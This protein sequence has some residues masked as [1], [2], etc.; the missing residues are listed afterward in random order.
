MIAHGKVI[1]LGEHAVVF[2][3][4]ALAGALAMGVTAVASAASADRLEIPSWDPAA[5]WMEDPA[6]PLRRALAAIKAALDVHAPLAIVAQA[7]LPPG[8][9]L[10]SSAA[11]AVAL[12]RAIAAAAGRDLGDDEVERA[13]S[14]AERVFH[15]NPSGID[16]A[17]ATRGGI[18]LFRRGAGLER[19]AVP[20]LR[21]AIG[22]SGEPRSTA[23]RVA[24]VAARLAAAPADTERLLARLGELALEGR[25]ALLAG[26]PPRLGAAMEEA[27][28]HL[29]ALG[30]S[31]P[32]LDRLC[33]L[34]TEAGAFG[35][36]L[37][38]A[39]GGGAAI[40]IGNED[41]VAAAWR[42]AGFDARVAE[43]GA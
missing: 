29:R 15:A 36:K 1:L 25:A 35:A 41:A 11:L 12:V 17:L 39:G 26:D 30:V 19:L 34:A 24:A 8:A 43:V 22:L 16:V 40:A 21:L 32:G 6:H 31:S 37:T 33:A 42:A 23:A 2:G 13:A 10:G 27:Q 3:H 9:G 20:P 5:P 7:D 38:G 28:R 14:E 18:G 4:P